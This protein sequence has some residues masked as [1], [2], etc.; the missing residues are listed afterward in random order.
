MSSYQS[1]YQS[2]AGLCFGY[3]SSCERA[4]MH[5]ITRPGT[6]SL[7]GKRV[8]GSLTAPVMDSP[9]RLSQPQ[10]M[11]GECLDNFA[12]ADLS[13]LFKIMNLASGSG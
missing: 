13:H 2:E 6:T 4:S 1:S 5:A 9:L 11:L 7:I 3:Q 8:V 10:A 12:H